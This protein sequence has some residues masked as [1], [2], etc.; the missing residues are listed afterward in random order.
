MKRL[1]QLLLLCLPLAAFADPGAF[2][3]VEEPVAAPWKESDYVLPPFP[4]A[5]NLIEFYV[6]AAN[7]AKF[8]IDQSSIGAGTPDGVVR[9]VMVVRTSGGAVNTSYEGVRCD[10]NEY[11][12]YATGNNDEGTWNKARGDAWRT[13]W[14]GSAQQKSLANLYLCP[15]FN[16][17]KTA[18]EG[19]QALKFGGHPLVKDRYVG[20]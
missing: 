2:N 20:G 4:K 7:P 9:Y 15:D 1:V 5:E 8:Y 13:F 17:V 16:P 19:R 12:I 6:S 3:D 18:E 14:R 10:T 11:R